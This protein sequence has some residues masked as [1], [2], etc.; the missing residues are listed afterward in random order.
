MVR[1]CRAKKRR[2]R[3]EL[4]CGVCA[5]VCG[6]NFKARGERPPA[7]KTW[8]RERARACLFALLVRAV[9]CSALPIALVRPSHQVSLAPQCG[10]GVISSDQR[11]PRRFKSVLVSER[12]DLLSRARLTEREREL[13]R[14]TAVVA[15]THTH[16]RTRALEYCKQQGW[17]KPVDY[18]RSWCEIKRVFKTSGGSGPRAKL[19]ADAQPNVFAQRRGIPAPVLAT[20]CFHFGFRL[21]LSRRL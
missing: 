1:T 20:C 12:R 7:Q 21:L 6:F 9:Q 5:D 8:L 4:Q 19:T 14:P 17:R 11:S 13:E 10:S 15:R 18:R 3:E 16:T 2:V